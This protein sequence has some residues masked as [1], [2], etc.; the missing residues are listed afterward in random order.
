MPA[1]TNRK[2]IIIVVPFIDRWLPCR[3]AVGGKS[4]DLI[5]QI[6]ANGSASIFNRR[7]AHQLEI[8]RWGGTAVS[9]SC[10]RSLKTKYSIHNVCPLTTAVLPSTTREYSGLLKFRA[11]RVDVK[12]DV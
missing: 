6:W 7:C 8:K 5:Y 9:V 11:G 4:D 3:E 12:L 10:T 2:H 1:F